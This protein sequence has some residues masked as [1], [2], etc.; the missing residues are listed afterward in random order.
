MHKVCAYCFFLCDFPP[1][2]CSASV[3]GDNCTSGEVCLQ[4]GP[5]V[6]EGR[7]EVCYNNQ[8]GAVCE[9]GWDIT[10]ANV[11]CDQLGYVAYGRL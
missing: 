7:V 6:F 4:G 8:W 5:T 11:V 10:D 1:A 3:A 9:D 2:V